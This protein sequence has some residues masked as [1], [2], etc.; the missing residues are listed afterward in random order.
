MPDQ[1]GL[2]FLFE[3]Q[4]K[5]TADLIKIEKKAVA[6]A[7]NI[8]KAFSKA[9]QAQQA[10]AA[11]VIHTSKL[12]SIAVENA[13][14]KATAARTK[15]TKQGQILAQRLASAQS[16]EARRAENFRVASAKRVAA[17]AT[18]T[19]K[20][21]A[22]S[23]KAQAK[24]Q[25][26][27]KRQSEATTRSVTRLA[28]A[29]AVAFG[30]VAG[31]A[32]VMAGGYDKAMRSVQA[33]TQASGE[34]MDRLSE[35][36]REMGRTT[37]HSA[38]EAAR[39]QAFLAQAGFDANAILEAL[40][41]TL[42]LATAGELD[43]ASAADIASNVLSGFQLETKETGRVADVLALAASKTNTSVLQLGSALA[44]AAPAAKAAGWS[45]E[46][47]TAAIGKLSDAGIQGEEAGTTLNTMLAKLSIN[48][49]PAEKLLAKMGI[50]VKD[51]S[52]N[53][54]PLNDI[55]SALAPH[56]SDVG[57]QMELLGTRGAKAGFIL[58]AVAQDA[59]ELTGELENA[60]G[61]AQS[62]AD[63]MSGGLWG[64]LK[65]IGSIVDSAFI[66]LG[67]RLAPALQKVADL[68]AKLPSP[69]Q[70]VV[71]VV[72]SLVGAM[73]GLMLLMP[74]SFGALVQLPG[75]LIK[76]AKGLK[77]VTAAQWLYNTALTANPIGL[78]VAAVALLAGGLYLLWKRYKSVQ[79]AF[80]ASAA[81]TEDLT[82]RYDE[83]TEKVAAATA[84]L[85][86]AQ[87]TNSRALPTA[88][89]TLRA[90]VAQRDE[91]DLHIQQRA[92]T[93]KAAKKLAATEKK[94]TK[95][96][97]KAT[98][99]QLKAEKAAEDTAKAVQGLV[100]S[101]TGA[102]LKSGEFLKA[103][104][105]LTP[106]QRDNDRIMGQVIGKYESMRKVL[107]PFD[108]ELEEL[109][110]TNQILNEK[111]E[112]E[113]KALKEAT[114]AQEDATKAAD[115]LN[116][117]L[118][119]QRLRLLGL[120]TAAAIQDFEE[121][122]QTWEDLSEAEKTV[123]TPKFAQALIDASK[124]G[125]EL[126]DAQVELIDSSGVLT[127]EQ[128]K[129][130]QEAEELNDRLEKQRRRL[131]NLPTEA[132]IQSFAE[133][134]QTWEGLNEA[135]REVATKEYSAAL[136][137]AA[138][139]GHTL[140]A[141]QIAIIESTQEATASASGY[142]LALAGIASGMGGATGQALNLI[143]AMREHN[144]EQKKAAALGKKTEGSFGKMRTGAAGL[145][146]AFS[147]VGDMV[148]GTAG[149]VMKELSGIAKAFATG[150]LVAGIIAGIMALGKAIWG[151]FTRGRKKRAAARKKEAAAA[152]KVADAAKEAADT[153]AEAVENLRLAWLNLP[154]EQIVLDLAAIREA[155]DALGLEDRTVAFDDYVASLISAR[156]AGAE[157]TAAELNLITVFEEHQGKRTA[158]LARHKAEMS[159]FESQIAAL[160]SLLQTKISEVDAL[161]SQ[162][163]AE[164]D[165]LSALQDAE[166]EALAARRQA[167]LDVDQGH[168]QSRAVVDSQRELNGRNWTR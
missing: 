93:E 11:K 75:K 161:I 48:G 142:E 78:V 117:R 137:E 96:L 43:L 104:K 101:W 62:M 5:I 58:G 138:Q 21:I 6:S 69:I 64:S 95:I 27:L 24:A 31:K 134:T 71:V 26:D 79:E 148:G 109:W 94:A 1:D 98:E 124:A 67:Q 136:H 129:L 89:K 83:L 42:A 87:E 34:L 99:E 66:S 145:A 59:R 88:A 40:P 45:L 72:G 132:A 133:L 20:A 39:G 150:G 130:K 80:D 54:L 123:A 65:Q 156:D 131:L 77:L 30:A 7:K 37:V 164:L 2:R 154:T 38:T 100:D 44:K 36:S 118:E 84:K 70:E 110:K 50:T 13:T 46:E 8:D 33:K 52:G 86:R 125:F 135:E 165:A 158:M 15:E 159:G 128:E 153:H 140:D 144:K 112:A 126:N 35:Q 162:Q 97:K 17:A 152:K 168:V 157:L 115:A 18:K 141:A 57:L 4:D 56:A 12:R 102:T 147:A 3:I 29:S 167:A 23:A 25:R 32:L 105:K 139:A 41:A 82:A 85:E 16:T 9:S 28:S 143:I 155:W 47:T 92:E 74:Q 19:E 151:L 111:L 106:A 122:T 116:A 90:L 53:M 49:G 76:L 160:E 60:E 146:T 119:A 114:K 55:L 113:E 81:S 63:V 73:G 14:A 108:D 166:M 22:A 91:L 120:P 10:N 163:K 149:K 68:F 127:K 103:F 107:G 51:T 61:S 121:L